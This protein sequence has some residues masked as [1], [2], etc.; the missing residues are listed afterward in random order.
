MKPKAGILKLDN[1][2]IK[3]G[4]EYMLKKV[5]DGYVQ[6]LLVFS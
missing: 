2:E 6:K 1:V 4:D 5:K 3:V